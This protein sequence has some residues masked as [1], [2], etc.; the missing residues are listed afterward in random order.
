[1]TPLAQA[2]PGPTNH[3]GFILGPTVLG[4]NYEQK[5]K[6]GWNKNQGHVNGLQGTSISPHEETTNHRPGPVESSLP[7]SIRLPQ[8]N[9]TSL[10]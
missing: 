8:T 9:F 10:N 7:L 2:G 5:N 1:M 4:T 6:E 3:L